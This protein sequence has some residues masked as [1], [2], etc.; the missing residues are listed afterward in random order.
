M[1]EDVLSLIDDNKLLAFIRSSQA[2]DAE[3]IIKALIDGGIRLF[4][5][6]VN[7][8]QAFKLI[9]NYSKQEGVLVGAGSVVDG[10]VA[11]RAIH[12]GARF[13]MSPY[14]DKDVI[15]VCKNNNS[16][17]IQGAVTPTEVISAMGLGVD[18]VE[19]YPVS[20]FGGPAYIKALK[21][22]LPF[23]KLVPSGGITVDNVT[24][25]LKLGVSAVVLGGDVI[26]KSLIRANNWDAIR[27]RAQILSEKLES[28]R[29]VKVGAP[30]NSKGG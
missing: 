27:E 29:A 25:Y 10:E 21:G 19:V 1:G 5:I 24:D 26:E 4:Q 3:S 22:P 18:L 20:A 30:V 14:T 16:V 17:V 11:Q 13:I 23:T 9:E 15:L 8:P 6:S 12:A 28:M 7:V 2:E